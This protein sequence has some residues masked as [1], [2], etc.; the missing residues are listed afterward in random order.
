MKINWRVRVR[1]KLFWASLI[2]AVILLLQEVLSLCGVSFEVGS[3]ADKIGDIVNSILG[4]LVILG[5]V[6]D[7]TTEGV[8]DSNQALG[9]DEPKPK[10]GE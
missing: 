4:I 9:Y 3:L 1:N 7:P 6:T 2:P 5:V 10:E 8:C